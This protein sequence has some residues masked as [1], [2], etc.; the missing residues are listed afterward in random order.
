M[1][2]KKKIKSGEASMNLMGFGKIHK[3]QYEVNVNF[4]NAGINI[5]EDVVRQINEI[6]GATDIITLDSRTGILKYK[7]ETIVPPSKNIDNEKTKLLFI[8]GNPATHSIENGMFFF[9]QAGENH[10]RHKFW[11]KLAKTCLLKN[12][13]LKTR[14]Q[15]AKIRRELI[16]TGN[17]NNRF[18]IGFTTFYSMPTPT[19]IHG[20]K[21]CD[22]K[23]V[24]KF[25][26]SITLLD[27]IKEE[28]FNRINAYP[29]VEDAILITTVKSA[30]QYLSK[31]INDGRV[32]CWPIR[33]KGSGWKDLRKILD[34]I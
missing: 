9:S 16:L 14:K 7:L 34:E 24:E 30:Y 11:G 15:E 23:D 19:G 26:N 13:E 17:T 2:R 20:N 25:F 32:K 33:G 27:K 1:K 4:N 21:Y 3:G 6:N 22:S 29:F 5:T 31:K 8:L 10:H 28:E 18:V 12:F